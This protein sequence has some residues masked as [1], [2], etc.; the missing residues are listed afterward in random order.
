MLELRQGGLMSARKAGLRLYRRRTKSCRCR[1]HGGRTV[2]L[3]RVG[4]RSFEVVE[5]LFV[6]LFVLP[7]VDADFSLALLTG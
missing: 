4:R 5:R 7:A 1:R 6:D 3:G 2:L